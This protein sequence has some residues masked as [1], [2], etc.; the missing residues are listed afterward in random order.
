MHDCIGY[1]LGFFIAILEILSCFMSHYLTLLYCSSFHSF[2]LPLF[3]LYLLSPSSSLDAL[4][5]PMP[6][7]KIQSSLLI[8]VSTCFPFLSLSIVSSS[9]PFWSWSQSNL[10]LRIPWPLFSIGQI[11]V[12]DMWQACSHCSTA[13]CGVRKSTPSHHHLIGTSHNQISRKVHISSP[14]RK[15]TPYVCTLNEKDKRWVHTFAVSL[16]L[17]LL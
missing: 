14:N 7:P 2:H 9:A 11:L 10:S 12:N 13:L 1:P 16:S 17:F 4:Y 6:L 3:L 15:Q 5:L 8:S